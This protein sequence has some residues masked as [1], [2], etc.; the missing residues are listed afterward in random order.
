[1]KGRLALLTVVA[2]GA[3]ER[4]AQPPPSGQWTLFDLDRAA[5]AGQNVLVG[6]EGFPP[7]M[8]ASEF[9]ARKS[10][11][12]AGPVVPISPAFTEG[13]PSPYI[14]TNVWGNFPVVWI[15]PMYI[16][17]THFDD[18]TSR[19]VTI[20]GAKWIFTVGPQSRFHSPFWQIYWA[21]VPPGTAPDKYT[22]SEQLLRDRV[23][24]KPGPGRLVALAP[25]LTTIEEWA[26]SKPGK[27]SHLAAQPTTPRVRQDYL[28]GKL[29]T[30]LD[31]G[32][33]RF[34]WNAQGEVVEQPF[35]V[36]AGHVG[37]GNYLPVSAPNVGGTGPLF[38]RRP[39]IA[40]RNRPIFGS[41]WR[42]YLVKLPP[43]KDAAVFLPRS[44]DR[45]RA[46]A[47]DWVKVL[48]VPAIGWDPSTPEMAAAVS[49]RTMQVALNKDCF[50]SE[51]AFGTC[52]WL[53]SQKAIEEAL[54]TSIERTGIT[55]TCPFVGYDGAVVPMQ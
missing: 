30:G 49:A 11:D 7:G 2:L 5:H 43:T 29:V 18:A 48:D 35:F 45:V 52:R 10:M 19:W 8:P 47:E 33:N 6:V 51:A 44:L 31:F 1:M 22:S 39:P 28:D 12:G 9:L 54:P 21:I 16:L 34:E 17:A 20:P 41:Y 13:K 25:D 53:D 36:F 27:V 23:E 40:P 38:E 55:V 46:E 42:L 32:D 37:D 24:L 15:Q 14:T 50:A 3:C 4:P 26:Q